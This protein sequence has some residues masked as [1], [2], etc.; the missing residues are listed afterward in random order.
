M[1]NLNTNQN[2]E[3]IKIIENVLQQEPFSEIFSKVDIIEIKNKNYRYEGL[4]WLKCRLAPEMIKILKPEYQ[5]IT[6][7]HIMPYRIKKDHLAGI[8][9]YNNSQIKK[10]MDEEESFS[11]YDQKSGNI[12]I[13]PNNE[14]QIVLYVHTEGIADGPRWKDNDNAGKD[15]NNLIINEK[16]LINDNFYFPKVSNHEEGIKICEK[17]EDNDFKGLKKYLIENVIN[18]IFN[19]Q[20]PNNQ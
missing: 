19:E 7:I 17:L 18:I 9:E 15:V 8:I 13:T 2:R 1:K 14:W 10:F 16:Y 12:H 20:C 4:V 6:G 5:G 3:K 11:D